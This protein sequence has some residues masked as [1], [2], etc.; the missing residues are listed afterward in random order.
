M[1][2]MMRNRVTSEYRRI[3][4]DSPEFYELR[5]TLHTDGR[6]MWEQTGE[7]DASAFKARAEAG[8]LRAEDIGD[9]HQPI[10][11]VVATG[12]AE[13]VQ[14][15]RGF[16]TPGEIE[17]KAGRAASMSDEELQRLSKAYGMTGAEGYP[18][19]H[20][21]EM[22]EDAAKEAGVTTNPSLSPSGTSTV[23]PEDA[24][25]ATIDANQEL[26]ADSGEPGV[27]DDDPS[28]AGG[29]EEVGEAAPID[30]AN[31]TGD[32]ITG[33]YEQYN[34]SALA[35]ECARRDPPVEPVRTDGGTGGLRKGDYVAALE[36]YDR[37]Y[38]QAA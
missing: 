33:S 1:A 6:P 23:I 22:D 38:T 26:L 4:A 10:E 20:P 19:G 35:A 16:P 37:N 29:S 11:R 12:G 9:A 14:L 24:H 32:P 28:E 27:E 13:Q 21:P 8:A 25:N 3:E 5:A 2:T 30:P 31:P 18:A 34:N 36:Q 7:H 15:D 17:Q